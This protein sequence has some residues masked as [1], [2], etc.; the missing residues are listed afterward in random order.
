[1]TDAP[2]LSDL[3]SRL[4]RGDAAAADEFVRVYG[5]AVRITVR[6]RLTD[7]ALRRNWWRRG[8]SRG[9]ASP[10]VHPGTEGFPEKALDTLTPAAGR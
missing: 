9:D 8:R 4:R 6:T 7:P 2:A 5:P 1:M 10:A 3:L